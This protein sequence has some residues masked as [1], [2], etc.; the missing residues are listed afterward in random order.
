MTSQAGGKGVNISRAAVAA[1]IATVAVLP[2]AEDD[3]FVLELLAAGIDC[4]P[5]PPAGDVRVNLTIT[6]PDGTTTKLNSPG[7]AVDRR[8]RSTTWRQALLVAR[9]HAPTGSCWPAR[10]RPARPPGGT[11]SWCAALRARRRRV[12]VDTS[13]AP[14]RGPG[15]RAARRGAPT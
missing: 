10:C 4:R 11:P 3:P 8:A 1:G 14:A 7:A 9:R 2:A 5:V 13:E 6:E 15:R 12:A